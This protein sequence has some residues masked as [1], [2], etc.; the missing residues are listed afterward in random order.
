MPVLYEYLRRCMRKYPAGQ[1]IST[2][3]LVTAV[4]LLTPV[5]HVSCYLGKPYRLFQADLSQHIIAFRSFLKA[6]GVDEK[7]QKVIWKKLQTRL[8]GV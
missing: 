8:G 1:R 2:N 3:E 7:K 5:E 4:E 6:R